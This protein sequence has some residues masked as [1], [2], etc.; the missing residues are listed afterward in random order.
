[1]ATVPPSSTVKS[2]P[3]S[4]RTSPSGPATDLPTSCTAIAVAMLGAVVD[5]VSMGVSRMRMI[6][7]W[8]GMVAGRPRRLACWL[9]LAASLLAP[10]LACAR[11]PATGPVLVV[12]DSLRDL[13][14]IDTAGGLPILVLTGKGKKTLAAGGLP[15]STQVFD[16][17]LSFAKY[18]NQPQPQQDTLCF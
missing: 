17:L 18:L 6:E 9:L 12:G 10:V 2:T 16:D 4:I 7:G 8:R 13:Q 1:M 5:R 14:A 11:G 3:S 15:E